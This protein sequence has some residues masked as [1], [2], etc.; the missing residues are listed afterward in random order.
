MF[1]N[2]R[3]RAALISLLILLVFL[4]SWHIATLPPAA[5]SKAGAAATAAQDEYALL[6]G[7]GATETVRN[8]GFPTPTQMGATVVQQL[9]S[10]FYDNGPNDKGIGIQ[11]GYSVARVAI[12]FLLAAL[13]AI[14]LGFL[15]GMSPLMQR[16]LDPFIQIL[17]PVSPLAWMPTPARLS[18]LR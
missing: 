13:V 11:L 7:K 18:L 15:L 9:A 12:G 17:K 16:A 6:M 4:L 2:I 3:F 5:N 10:P 1:K 14:P 8:S